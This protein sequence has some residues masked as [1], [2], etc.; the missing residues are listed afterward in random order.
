MKRFTPGAPLAG[1][2]LEDER[3]P[4]ANGAGKEK[5]DG[6]IVRVQCHHPALCDARPRHGNIIIKNR[7]SRR[8]PAHANIEQKVTAFLFQQARFALAGHAQTHLPPPARRKVHVKTLAAPAHTDPP[9]LG[10]GCGIDLHVLFHVPAEAAPFHPPWFWS[11]PEQNAVEHGFTAGPFPRC[12]IFLDRRNLFPDHAT[13]MSLQNPVCSGDFLDTLVVAAGIKI[14]MMF[15]G[16]SFIGFPDRL[17]ALTRRDV[18]NPV[19]VGELQAVGKCG[20][21]SFSV[22][23]S[24][25][26]RSW[27]KAP[28]DDCRDREPR[29]KLIS[30][31]LFTR[32]Y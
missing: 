18:E 21:H 16:E 3:F 28:R 17:P 11:R 15:P 20:V 19:T 7:F 30:R 6:A 31:S 14:G 13:K 8:L 22:Q 5:P 23:G 29:A 4:I 1:A 32:A 10:R 2:G 9:P 12:R 24:N 26:R 25:M 27:L